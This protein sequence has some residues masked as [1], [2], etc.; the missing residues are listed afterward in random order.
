MAKRTNVQQ[1]ISAWH[2]VSEL[3]IEQARDARLT[4]EEINALP[5]VGSA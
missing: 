2:A 5:T 3:A 4:L 1:T